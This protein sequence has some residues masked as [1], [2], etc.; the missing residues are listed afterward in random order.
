MI[1]I[2]YNFDKFFD[3][4]LDDTGTDMVDY[5]QDRVPVDSGKL[6]DSIYKDINDDINVIADTDYA[7]FVELGS[8][9][10]Q[11]KPYLRPTLNRAFGFFIKNAKEN[12]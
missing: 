12:W 2:T 6:R 1:T 11:P 8:N 4:T 10:T 9:K 3:K 7:V 5:A